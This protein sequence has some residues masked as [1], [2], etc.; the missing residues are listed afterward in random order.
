MTEQSSNVTNAITNITDRIKSMNDTS[1]TFILT[2]V[3]ISIIVLALIVYFFYT[4]TLFSNGL[5]KNGCSFMDTMYESV[6]GKIHSIDINNPELFKTE[7]AH[8]QKHSAEWIR[9]RGYIE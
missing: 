1:A 9:A 8:R 2:I 3:N 7:R 5:R 4:G 6:N